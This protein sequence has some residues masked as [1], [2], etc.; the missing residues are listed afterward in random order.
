MGL[1]GFGNRRWIRGELAEMTINDLSP[2][3]KDLVVFFS[4]DSRMK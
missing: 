4:R 3:I 1:I 2:F